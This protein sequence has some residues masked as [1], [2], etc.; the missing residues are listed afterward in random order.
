MASSNVGYLAKSSAAPFWP[1][2]AR[3]GQ[4]VR[5]VAAQRNKIRHLFRTDAVAFV[6]FRRVD[7][8]HLAGAHGMQNRRLLRGELKR[9]AVAAG[10]DGA[11]V[12]ALLFAR[13][14]SGEEIVGLEA[15]RFGVGEAAGG[16]EVRQDIE[17]LDQ[18]FVEMAAA[19]I[20]REKLWRY[21]G[22]SSVSQPTSTARGLSLS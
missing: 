6:H 18:R 12:A 11:A 2:A 8:R 10:D 20:I 9:V 19:L 1:D 22:A 14:R 3:A 16:D 17:L 21:V 5:G 13:Y 7:P 4:L 15:R